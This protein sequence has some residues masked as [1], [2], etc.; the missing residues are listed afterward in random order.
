MN[1]NRESEIKRNRAGKII[2]TISI[3]LIVICCFSG[4]SGRGTATIATIASLGIVVG[5][6]MTMLNKSKEQIQMDDKLSSATADLMIARTLAGQKNDYE[7]TPM[8]RA[9]QE[10]KAKKE[11]IKGAVVGGIIAGDAGAVVGAVVAKE[12]VDREKN[13]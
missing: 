12:K 13:R 11:I 2:L 8:G 4:S 3:I 10:A 5:F 9:E 7:S 1:N 6:F